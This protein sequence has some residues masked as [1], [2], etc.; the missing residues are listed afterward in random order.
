VNS[1]KQRTL[2]NYIRNKMYPDSLWSKIL[3][4]ENETKIGA[5][6]LIATVEKEYKWRFTLD[7]ILMCVGKV[8]AGGHPGEDHDHESAAETARFTENMKAG[9]AAD[10][11][12]GCGDLRGDSADQLHPLLSHPK[13]IYKK[14]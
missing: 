4:V 14:Q 9:G 6:E 5:G 13:F 1:V 8:F 10:Q 11:R 7:D 12:G 2:I 3:V